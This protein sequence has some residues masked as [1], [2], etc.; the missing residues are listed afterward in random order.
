MTFHVFLHIIPYPQLCGRQFIRQLFQKFAD[1][2]LIF[3]TESILHPVLCIF[4][5]A[6][7]KNKDKKFLKNESL[8]CRKKCFFIL[9]EMHLPHRLFIRPEMIFLRKFIRKKVILFPHLFQCLTECF[10]Y[11]IV[12]QTCCQSIDRL[13]GVDLFLITDCRIV[14]LRMFH[15]KGIS[16]L[17]NPA[18]ENNCSF[19]PKCIS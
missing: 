3:K 11:C 12:C 2:R 4:Y 13:H 9:R 7:R 16:F 14:N 17:H 19:S 1:L 15:H 18:A 10:D 6:Q 5:L 8:S